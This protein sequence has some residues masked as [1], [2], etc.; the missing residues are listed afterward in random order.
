MGVAATIAR[1]LKKPRYALL[2]LATS[3]CVFLL[4]VWAQNAM[5]L[6]DILISGSY[7]VS[8]K[9]TI[10]WSFAQSITT[11]FSTLAAVYIIAIAI[12]LGI[13]LAL[14]VFYIVQ[15]RGA[16]TDAGP[17]GSAAGIGGL[18]SGILGLGCAACGTAL[19]GPILGLVGAGGLL[20]VL[21]LHGEEF[22]LLSIALLL[23][24]IYLIAKR[25]Q[26][27]LVCP[28]E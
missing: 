25:I 23:I 9:A 22:G 24:S 11:N 20:A 1:V 6:W 13:N 21:P 28:I 16:F 5:L 3:V 17:T 19:V 2:A 10:F 15:R 8:T 26:S 4:A 27:P 14:V 7:R 18:V 12:L